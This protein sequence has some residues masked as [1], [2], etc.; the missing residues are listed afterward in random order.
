[1]ELENWE[2]GAPAHLQYWPAHI[3]PTGAG[4]W[5]HPRTFE[6][7][8]EAVTAAV[9]QTPPH[10]QLAWILTSAGRIMEPAEV[11]DLWLQLQ[12]PASDVTAPPPP[13]DRRG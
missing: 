7:L 3:N 9:T 4:A 11:E 8:R 6:T 2:L 12:A 10:S 5:D 13:L 1:M